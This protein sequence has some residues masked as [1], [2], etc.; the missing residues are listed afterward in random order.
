MSTSYARVLE[1]DQAFRLAS[2]EQM[3]TPVL[4]I[5]LDTVDSNIGATITLAGNDPNRLRPHIKTAKLHRVIRRCVE[6]GIHQ[7]KCA[8]TLE[9]E[10]ACAAGMRD[11]LVAYPMIG[12]NAR[13]IQELSAGHQ[14]T[15]LSVLVDHRQQI[16][17]W[18][19]SAGIFLDVN[20]GMDRTG[21][22]TEKV[23]EALELVHAIADSGH[24]F[25]GLHYYDGHLGSLGF[26]ERRLV[27]TRGYEQ[28]VQMAAAIEG[29]GTKVGEVITSGSS[30]CMFACTYA[31]LARAQFVHRVSP[32]AA[33]YCDLNIMQQ[34]PEEYGY[35]PAAVV[36]TRVVSHPRADLLTCDAGLKA[37]AGFAGL[38]NCA[39]L[40]RPDL[41]PQRMSEEH[42]TLQAP[43]GS[44][45]P[46]LGSILYLVPRHAGLTVNNF[47]EA[48]VVTSDGMIAVEPVSARGHE[49]P[50]AHNP[51]I[52]D[53][54]DTRLPES[55]ET[56]QD[57]KKVS[58]RSTT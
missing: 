36:A 47:D 22:S 17:Q 49:P 13:R 19:A 23:D 31:P 33:L 46:E 1:S 50:T 24:T 38:P 14:G 43:A 2:I 12:A 40:G 51:R 29:A 53:S 30:V 42:L 28:L 34:I 56:P 16:P 18:N 39:V 25:R 44:A 3:L 48:L 32:G 15:T 55:L 54:L 4:L 45:L 21:I 37:V 5:Y 10:V 6:L 57:Q 58:T 7:C 35:R 9:F 8:T 41:A 52:C 20:P 11:V 27:A 26:E